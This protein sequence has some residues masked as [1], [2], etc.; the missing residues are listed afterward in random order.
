MY[1]KVPHISGLRRA[2]EDGLDPKVRLWARGERKGYSH[3]YTGGRPAL[4]VVG[5]TG[6]T[7]P[8]LRGG[9]A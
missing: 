4:R 9:T 6:A 2:N 5:H 1:T 8:N 3:R 7:L